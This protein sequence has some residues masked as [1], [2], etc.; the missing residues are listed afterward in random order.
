MDVFQQL[1][2]HVLPLYALIVVGF[3]AK[4][5][6]N[7]ESK[8]ISKLL[9]YIL[10][11]LLIVENLLKANLSETMVIGSMV[12][13]LALTMNLPAILCKRFF[14]KDF[15]GSLL[16]GSFS[17]YNI[18]WFGIP[19]VM[20]LFGSKEMPLIISAYVGNVLYG[21]T[22]GYYLMS[23]TKG[24]GVT[25][26]VKNIFKI[27][28]IYACLIAILLNI[29]KI[30]LPKG[31]EAIGSVISWAASALGM[32][33]IGITLAELNFKQI[34]YLTFTK[35]L[36]IR[37]L[38]GAV[39]LITLVLLEKQF[40][41]VLNAEKSNLM[42]LISGFPIAANLVVFASFLETEKANSALLVGI[43]SIISLFLVPLL[44]LLLF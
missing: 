23:R 12:F 38:S 17:Y 18:G 44:C 32:L 7:L 27:P 34:P 9:L 11:P 1:L 30:E 31:A 41:Q 25:K 6:W 14:A 35:I 33:I 20:A 16:K 13:V 4:R 36:A 15:N 24:L 43:S 39:F 40:L 28:A 2:T 8:W 42:L 3:F 5:R 22:I 19:V 26:A 37:Y 21:D 10:I 29:T